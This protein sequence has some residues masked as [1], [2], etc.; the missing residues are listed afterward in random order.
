M[1]IG[2]IRAV[3]R[4]KRAVAQVEL[5]PDGQ[6]KILVNNRDILEYMQLNLKT[7]SNIQDP[8]ET[9]GLENKYD[10]IIKVSGGGIIGQ[11]Q[12]IRLGIARALCKV[13]EQVQDPRSYNREVKDALKVKGFLTQDSRCKERKKYGLKKAR[14]APQFSKR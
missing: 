5:L 9:L 2:I 14:R 12:A 7:V 3:G 10:A 4:R 8:L 1:V 11:A 13:E 6:G